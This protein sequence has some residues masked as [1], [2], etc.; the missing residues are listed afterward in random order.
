MGLLR[1]GD[2]VVS[3]GGSGCGLSPWRSADD[4][5][6]AGAG[7]VRVVATLEADRLV[8]DCT[9]LALV[10]GVGGGCDGAPLGSCGIPAGH[11]MLPRL[12]G[13]GGGVGVDAPGTWVLRECDIG[14]S[15]ATAVRVSRPGCGPVV[16]GG[17][18][19]VAVEV[20]DFNGVGAALG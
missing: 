9:V 3:L 4:V 6:S 5:P 16:G 1:R 15:P 10:A 14:L 20:V 11:P 7:A 19:A 8:G 2:V 18:A 12:P 17:T 13:V